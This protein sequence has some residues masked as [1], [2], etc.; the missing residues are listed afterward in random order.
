MWHL[1]R[2]TQSHDKKQRYPK[3]SW[4]HMESK[5]LLYSYHADQRWSPQSEQRSR[6]TPGAYLESAANPRSVCYSS[7]SKSTDSR[8]FSFRPFRERKDVLQRSFLLKTATTM[9]SWTQHI[10][11]TC[12]AG[13]VNK[14]SWARMC[15][16]QGNT[17]KNQFLPFD[18]A[19]GFREVI[20]ILSPHMAA[21]VKWRV[22]MLPPEWYLHI[23]WSSSLPK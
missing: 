7:S 3:L 5:V 10:E 23:D 19:R 20:P 11:T 21:A 15:G 12:A 2:S 1:L 8:N 22:Q 9:S 18:F 16:R 14:T 6:R 4:C 17:C 13:W